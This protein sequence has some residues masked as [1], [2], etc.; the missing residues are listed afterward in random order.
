MRGHILEW[1]NAQLESESA[2]E[3]FYDHNATYGTFEMRCKD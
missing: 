2:V 3:S 1:R